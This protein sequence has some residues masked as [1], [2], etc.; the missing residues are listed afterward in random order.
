LLPENVFTST[1][2]KS[3]SDSDSNGLEDPDSQS[4]SRF[5]QAKIVPEKKENFFKNCMFNIEL[6]ASPGA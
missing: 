1:L 4:G 3:D 6:G 5:W 2:K